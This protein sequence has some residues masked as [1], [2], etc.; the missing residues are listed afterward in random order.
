MDATLENRVRQRAGGC[1]EYCQLPEKCAST[2]FEVDHIVAE[3]HGGSTTL[4]NLAWAC[5]GCNRS[6]G[7]NLGGID[8]KTGKKVWL[9]HPRRQKWR[10]H[11]RWDGSL[12]IGRSPVGRVTIAVLGINLPQRIARRA[13]LMDEDIFPS[14]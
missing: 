1:C 2:P 12:L 5:F 10:R 8:S 13:A 3:Q 7:P 4:S 6:K 9:F 14:S 11:F